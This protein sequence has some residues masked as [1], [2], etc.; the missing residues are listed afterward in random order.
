[1]NELMEDLKNAGSWGEMLEQFQVFL[2]SE[3]PVPPAVLRRALADDMF[4]H[5][6]IVCRNHQPHLTSLFNDPRNRTYE[7]P[8]DIEEKSSILLA[9]KAAKAF[10]K[11]GKAGFSQVDEETFE[12]RFSACESC[13]YLVQ[14]PKKLIYKLVASKRSD[15]RVCSACGCVA[16]RKARLSTESCPVAGRDNPSLNRWG[17]PMPAKDASAAN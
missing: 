2:G 8:D 13:E 11:W 7:R 17:Q 9:A 15:Q 3:K 4:A 6:L 16:S 12:Q 5:Y 14:P 1:M 10:M